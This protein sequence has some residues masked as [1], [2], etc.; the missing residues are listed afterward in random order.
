MKKIKTLIALD[1]L[2]FSLQYWEDVNLLA[3]MNFQN[4]LRNYPRFVA[5]NKVSLTGSELSATYTLTRSIN[6][7]RSLRKHLENATDFNPLNFLPR[8]PKN[9]R[10]RISNQ[11]DLIGLVDVEQMFLFPLFLKNWLES[12]KVCEV[13]NPDKVALIDPG[14]ENYLSYLPYDNFI[15]S[16]GRPAILT[17]VEEGRQ[18]GRILSYKN[19]FISKKDNDLKILAIPDKVEEFLMKPAFKELVKSIINLPSKTKEEKFIRATAEL[20]AYTPDFARPQYDFLFFRLDI[21]TG[22]I[23]HT[24]GAFGWKRTNILGNVRMEMK[25]NA[26]NENDTDLLSLLGERW[27]MMMLPF[28]LN[29]MGKLFAEYIPAGEIIL[30]D[31]EDNMPAV[32]VEREDTTQTLSE[33]LPLTE[34]QHWY[35]VAVNNVTFVNVPKSKTKGLGVKIHTGREMPAHLRRKHVRHYR[36]EVGVIVR[37]TIIEQT[38]VRKDKLKDAP[39]HGS[40]SKIN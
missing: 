7:Y 33:S 11:E 19:F 26:V 9:L 5:D 14:S 35:E 1:Q 17:R 25:E 28:F 22:E 39:I 10:D 4:V 29:G 36:N 23:Y 15:L 34:K 3:E 38:T 31:L 12:K 30:H 16:L 6:E 13:S 8:V 27:E 21:P 32:D 40:L 24:D 20:E 2:K 37:T 18:A